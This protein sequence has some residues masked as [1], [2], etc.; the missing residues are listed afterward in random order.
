MK[1]I[2]DICHEWLD[3][4][5]ETNSIIDGLAQALKDAGYV[6]ISETKGLKDG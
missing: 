1:L 3:E 5:L 2:K 4:A 6:H